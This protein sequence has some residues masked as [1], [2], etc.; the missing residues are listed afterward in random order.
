MLKRKHIAFTIEKKVEIIEA[1][2]RGVTGQSLSERYGVGRTVESSADNDTVEDVREIARTLRHLSLYSECAEADVHWWDLRLFWQPCLMLHS[3]RWLT[4]DSAEQ[5]FQLT[6][7]EEIVDFVSKK[8]ADNEEEQQAAEDKEERTMVTA[9]SEAF[10]HLDA[11][12]LWFEDVAISRWARRPV[13]KR[14]SRE[15][16]LRP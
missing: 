8:P 14:A 2:K 13:D 1:L 9:H 10:A 16:H 12:L 11:A 4:C 5:G 3:D 15:L 7:D 6:N